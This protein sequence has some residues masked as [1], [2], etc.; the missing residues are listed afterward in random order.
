MSWQEQ[1][2]AVEQSLKEV[3]D[4][5]IMKYLAATV[6]TCT[7][8]SE[9]TVQYIYIYIYIYIYMR[10]TVYCTC[11]WH[12]DRSIDSRVPWSLSFIEYVYIIYIQ[13]QVYCTMS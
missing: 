9:R 7:S 4:L 8:I 1:A 6:Y 5:W 12:D 2:W 11:K 3:A 10:Y 13:Y